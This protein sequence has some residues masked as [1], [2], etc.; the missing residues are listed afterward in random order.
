MQQ[1]QAATSFPTA[2]LPS[3]GLAHRISSTRAGAHLTRCLKEIE[4]GLRRKQ[5]GP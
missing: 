5:N 1:T 4:Y 3:C 2:A